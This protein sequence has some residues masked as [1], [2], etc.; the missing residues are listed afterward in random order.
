MATD[1][2]KDFVRYP[3]TIKAN[4]FLKSVLPACKLDER[5]LRRELI[6]GRKMTLNLN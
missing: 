2:K 3:H 4:K 6:K 1:E 5:E